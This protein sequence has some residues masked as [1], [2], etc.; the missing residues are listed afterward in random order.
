MW[1]HK[2]GDDTDAFCATAFVELTS[3]HSSEFEHFF[4]NKTRDWES[5]YISIGKILIKAAMNRIESIASSEKP[6]YI[7][8]GS[9]AGSISFLFVNATSDVSRLGAYINDELGIDVAAI[10]K[11]VGDECR[12]SLRSKTCN[13]E[14]IARQFKGGGHRGA[15]GFS[16][17]FCNYGDSILGVRQVLQS[18][19]FTIYPML[20]KEC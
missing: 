6:K 20:E 18:V 13:V 10:Y 2:A 17:G 4:T 3:P 7:K 8:P 9:G 5:H 11:I 15:A 1:E 19:M 12:V 14:A 16:M